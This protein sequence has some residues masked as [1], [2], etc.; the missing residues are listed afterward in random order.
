MNGDKEKDY[1]KYHQPINE[2]A[3]PRVLQI[4][5]EDVDDIGLIKFEE[6]AEFRYKENNYDVLCIKGTNEQF[7]DPHS[8]QSK[9]LREGI[10]WL[11]ESKHSP[12]L[13][14][15]NHGEISDDMIRLGE[16][17]G[18][19]LIQSGFNNLNNDP[20]IHQKRIWIRVLACYAA[21]GMAQSLGETLLK[22]GG[23]HN[24]I[25]DGKTVITS[26]Q[27]ETLQI[28]DREQIEDT[29]KKAS[30][31][32]EVSEAELK[33]I[34]DKLLK[35]DYKIIEIDSQIKSIKHELD[36][37]NLIIESED[38]TM[39]VD[40]ST[41]HSEASILE[42]RTEIEDK[43]I[44][45]NKNRAEFES[46]RHDLSEQIEVL[47]ERCQKARKTIYEFN[48]FLDLGP[49]TQLERG[50]SFNMDEFKVSPNLDPET[51]FNRARTIN[52]TEYNRDCFFRVIDPGTREKHIQHVTDVME[53]RELFKGTP[54][55]DRILHPPHRD[56]I[57]Q[58]PKGKKVSH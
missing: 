11:L 33:P 5:Y 12:I 17:I 15:S 30:E 18:R 14:I 28:P 27:N 43:L 39:E 29:L 55:L 7:Q 25:I 2:T 24:F 52:V 3:K 9:S 41:K 36:I 31:T 8:P 22:K 1:K 6:S 53:V 46:Q 44:N 40:V 45:L 51:F 16:H 20:K 48:K 4:L 38:N 32:L 42:K 47:K 23:L 34:K 21:L 13:S 57:T 37:V 54:H 58:I 56:P 49:D 35:I 50:E 19:L 26:T 10:Q